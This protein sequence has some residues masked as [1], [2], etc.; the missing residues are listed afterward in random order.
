MLRVVIRTL[1]FSGLLAGLASGGLALATK[2]NAAASQPAKPLKLSVIDRSH[3]GE[4]APPIPFEVKGGKV[5]SVAALLAAAK[6]KPVLV[7]LWATWCV[8]CIAEMPAL[9]ALAKARAGRLT[10]LAISEDLEGW[11][12]VDKFFAPGKFLGLRP[13]LDQPGNYAVKMGATGLPLSI[14]YGADGREK[15]RVNGPLKWTSAE[16]AA[17]LG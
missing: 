12:A 8:P 17:A 5:T 2:G 14:L 3:A 11:R 13:Y 9:D 16:V 4:P 7:N 10:V 6:G 15:W 1:L